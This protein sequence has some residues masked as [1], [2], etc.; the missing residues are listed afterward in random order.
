MTEPLTTDQVFWALGKMHEWRMMYHVMAGRFP[1]QIDMEKSCTLTWLLTGHELLPVPPP[2]FHSAPAHQ[3][4]LD[5]GASGIQCCPTIHDY[6]GYPGYV[7]M[8]GHPWKRVG[9]DQFLR[10]WCS[11]RDHTFHDIEDELW[12]IT[13]GVSNANSL[14]A[15][16]II[17]VPVPCLTYRRLLPSST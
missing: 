5:G 13:P 3:F 7:I 15:G 8:C 4:V 9:G 1:T 12:E 2:C 10:V 6:H 14:A 17:Q 11:P 16:R